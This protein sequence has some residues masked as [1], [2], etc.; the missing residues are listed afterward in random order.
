MIEISAS[1]LPVKVDE[2]VDKANISIKL[3]IHR[4]HIDVIDGKFVNQYGLSNEIVSKLLKI[5]GTKLPIDVHLM[6]ND[7]LNYI[8]IPEYKYANTIYVH[9]Q[10]TMQELNQLSEEIIN[11]K[12]TPGVVINPN[13]TINLDVINDF[14][15]VLMM[16]VVPGLSGQSMLPKTFDKLEE[17]KSLMRTH[18]LTHH[19]TLDGG[20]TKQ[21]LESADGLVDCCVMG[22][23]IY[24]QENWENNLSDILIAV[25]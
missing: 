25:K 21:H 17:L 19:I 4:L 1:L 24:N 11:I 18:H 23:A 6:V 3:G 7:P 15:A 13:E 12:C 5:Y 22:A 14:S 20:V 2:I 9:K 8:R 10:N 16:G